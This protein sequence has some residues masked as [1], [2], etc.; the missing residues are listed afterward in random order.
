MMKGRVRAFWLWQAAAVPWLDDERGTARRPAELRV[1]TPGTVAIYGGDALGSLHRD[2]DR[3]RATSCWGRSA[4]PSTPA[5]PRSS[6]GSSSCATAHEEETAPRPVAR[7]QTSPSS[8]RL[9]PVRSRRGPPAPISPRISCARR[10]S[11]AAASCSP[12]RAGF[13]RA[14]SSRGHR[15]SATTERSPGCRG[16]ET[17]WRALG[18]REPSP[19]DCVAVIRKIARRRRAPEGPEKTILLETLRALAAHHSRR[20]TVDARSLAQLPLWTSQGW[21]RDRS[22][23]RPVY[24]AN[25]PVLAEGLR[26]AL[27]LWEPGGELEQF[28]PLLGPLRV[29]ELRSADAQVIE[30]TLAHEDQDSTELF[31]AALRLL[32]EDLARNDPRLAASVTVPWENL[33][34]FGVSV[35]PRLELSVPVVAGRVREVHTARVV[36]KV[37]PALC[38]VF[39]RDPSVLPRV[40][41][42]GRALAALFGGD[43]RRLAQA[44]RAVCDQAE[45]GREARRVE[46]ANERA[47]RQ[48][49]HNEA[50]IERRLAGIQARTGAQRP[51]DRGSTGRAAGAAPPSG[52]AGNER[53]PADTASDVGVPR[54]LVDPRSLRLLD[55]L[56]RAE[57]GAPANSADASGTGARPHRDVHLPEPNQATRGPRNRS[58]LRAY[59]DLDRENVGLEILRMLFGTDRDEIVDLRAQRGVGADAIDRLGQFYELKVSA[60]AEPDHVRLTAAEVK[61]AR[62]TPGFFLVVVSDI[63]GIDARPTV[64][65]VVD[66]LGQ[67]RPTDDRGVTLSGVRV[68]RSLVFHFATSEE[69]DPPISEEE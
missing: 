49:M 48:Q 65:V 54:T 52:A 68:A 58:P 40:D 20:N 12:E 39:V 45:D 57:E 35:H 32:H 23:A 55:P 10:L 56:G 16:T 3:P 50:E 14:A 41:G 15:Y 60:G 6:T 69:P 31:R 44:W 29:S 13:L 17:L 7:S 25:D 42:G 51:A 64:R 62:T 2:L 4:S 5:A 26:G 1:R 18:L 28:R 66:P 43:P 67:L 33:G 21:V 8:I 36:A 38:T 11:A 61:R 63:E 47:R 24:A 19:D 59:S 9:C 53:Q 34:E 22:R 30:P 46:L 27:P 37:D